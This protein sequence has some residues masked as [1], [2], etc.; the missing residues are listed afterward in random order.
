MMLR[1]EKDLAIRTADATGAMY[2]LAQDPDA[3]RFSAAERRYI[4]FMFLSY[5][6]PGTTSILE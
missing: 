4:R 1:R 6:V 2:V 3:D 5:S